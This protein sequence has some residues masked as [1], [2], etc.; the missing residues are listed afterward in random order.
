VIL[1]CGRIGG[2]LFLVNTVLNLP[3]TLKG[4]GIFLTSLVSVNSLMRI[5]LCGVVHF[6]FYV[7]VY[8]LLQEIMHL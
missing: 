4:G 2:W 3:V 1:A 7:S 5:L 6:K 8:F